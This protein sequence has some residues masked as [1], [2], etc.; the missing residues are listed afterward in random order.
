MF[1]PF[2]L[3]AIGVLRWRPRLLPYLVGVHLLADLS[4]AAQLWPLRL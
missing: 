2:A 4:A 3:L 1:V